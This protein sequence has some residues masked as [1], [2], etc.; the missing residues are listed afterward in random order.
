MDNGF[1]EAGSSSGET[2]DRTGTLLGVY[3]SKKE[4]VGPNN[5][6][7]YNVQEEGKDKTTGVWGSAVLDGRFEEIPVGSIV[8]ITCKGKVQAKRGGAGYTD[9]EV[10]YKPPTTTSLENL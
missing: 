9:Y 1:I 2:W 4:N 3:V 5:S 6:M 8:K 7:L 10:F